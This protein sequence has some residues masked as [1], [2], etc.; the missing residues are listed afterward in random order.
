[1]DFS[2]VLE[3]VPAVERPETRNDGR[4][5][6]ALTEHLDPRLADWAIH[7]A[8]QAT[9]ATHRT[10][11]PARFEEVADA[12][13]ASIE[14]I[15]INL[16]KYLV[17]GRAVAS[18]VRISRAQR[19]TS[20]QAARIGIPLSSVVGGLRNLELRWKHTFFEL[21][22][23][24][25]P[26]ARALNLVNELEAAISTYFAV[27]I[28][29]DA[30][31]WRDEQS[32]LLEQ[33]LASQR[34]IIERIVA[35][36]SVDE[37]VVLSMLGLDPSTWHLGLIVSVRPGEDLDFGAFRLALERAFAQHHVTF[38]PIEH[39]VVWAF[40]SGQP[41]ADATERIRTVAEQGG[42]L[43]AVGLPATGIAGLRSTHLTAQSVHA[44]A[45]LAPHLG[46]V[47]DFAESGFVSLASRDREL[48]RWF[49]ESELGE[50]LKG[51]ASTDDLMLTLDTLYTHGGSLVR[52]AEALFVHRNTVA[53]RL[54]RIEDILGRDPL[55]RPVETQAALTLWRALRG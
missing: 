24:A 10:I 21:V 15:S 43:V 49:V 45:R 6:R 23:G 40:V 52:T 27:L 34:Q 19:A 3:R 12:I 9:V 32:R 50:L 22:I 4:T 41:V 35:G 51:G 18:A 39:D 28:E 46:P 33:R 54:K 5:I 20:V 26:A 42:G 36:R 47:L 31:I 30:R 25:F 17:A 7:I 29:E 38:L 2:E 44:L 16:I 14:S 8:S 55:A 48:A 13:G 37:A 11:S 1:V 53:Y